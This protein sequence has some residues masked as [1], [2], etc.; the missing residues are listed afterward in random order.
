MAEAIYES[1]EVSEWDGDKIN[2]EYYEKEYASKDIC[3][4]IDDNGYEN[5]EGD[6]LSMEEI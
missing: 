5:E 1:N 4:T 6:S 3:M 2:I